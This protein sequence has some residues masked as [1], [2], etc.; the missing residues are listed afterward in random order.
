MWTRDYFSFVHFH[1]IHYKLNRLGYY[2]LYYCFYV[3]ICAVLIVYCLKIL[4]IAV[5][6]ML[7]I[8]NIIVNSVFDWLMI[9]L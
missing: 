2:W 4:N 3:N 5:L 9:N 8:L 1:A 6:L 7:Y